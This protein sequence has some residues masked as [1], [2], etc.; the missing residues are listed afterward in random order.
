[1]KKYL[2]YFFSIGLMSIG[3]AQNGP[4]G[5][6][7][8]TTLNLWLKT[9]N[10]NYND[11]ELVDTWEDAS[12]N[13][14]NASQAEENNRPSFT[15]TSNLNGLP[16]LQFA[17]G[18]STATGDFLRI[19]GSASNFGGINQMSIFSAVRPTN[20]SNP[21]GQAIISKRQDTNTSDNY[22]FS[23][24]FWTDNRTY[25]D[26]SGGG[27]VGNR[28]D[29]G[30]ESVV[31]NNNN[32]LINASFDGTLPDNEKQEIFKNASST[33]GTND[34]GTSSI[35]A[36]DQ[37][38]TIGKI[39]VSDNRYFAGQIPEI[40]FYNTAV[41]QTQRNII[42]NY[43]SAKF[44][45]GI[46]SNDIYTFDDNASGDFD[47]HVIGIGQEASTDNHINSKGSGIIRVNNPTNLNDGEYLFIGSESLTETDVDLSS[48]DCSSS[49]ADNILSQNTWRVGKY[50]GDLG[51]VDIFFDVADFDYAPMN[52]ELVVSDNEDFTNPTIY[53]SDDPSGGSTIVAF[54]GINFNNGDYIKLRFASVQP[55]V[56]DG[57][58]FENGSGTSGEPTIADF[59]KKLIINGTGAELTDD[60]ACFCLRVETNQ[61]FDIGNNELSIQ[62]SLSNSG[63]IDALQGS[64]RFSESE[65]L[66]E[67]SGA[68]FDIGSLIVESDVSINTDSGDH[69]GVNNLLTVDQ[70]TLTTNDKLV[71]RCD[72]V[73]GAAQ[74]APVSGSIVGN[75]E[76]QQCYPAKRAWR[77]VS[78]SATT[79]TSIHA[80]W[81]ENA[82]G[83]END[84]NPGFGTHITGVSP[85]SANAD[86]AQDG[87]NGFDYNPSGN[88]S[89]FT[90]DNVNQSWEVQP[91]TTSTLTAGTPYRLL[92]RGD[93]SID[94]TSND[95]LPEDTRLRET[96]ALAVGTQN[97]SG[98]NAGNGAFNIFGNPY[99]A[100]VNMNEVF[101]NSTNIDT[102]A[103]YVWDPQIN[104]R[105]GYVTISL[106]NGDNSVSS[107][108]NAYLQPKQAAFFIADGNGAPTLTFNESYK[109]AEQDQTE[110]FSQ[111]NEVYLNMKLHSQESFTNGDK[112]F[113]G[114]RI[115]FN[116]AYTNSSEDDYPKLG[117]QDENLARAN[118]NYFAALEYR[119]MPLENEVLPLFINQYRNETYV[120]ELDIVGEL[121][122]E[123][124]IY[125]AYLDEQVEVTETNFVYE[126]EIDASIPESVAQ[127]RFELNFGSE[128]FSSEEFENNNISLYPN[129]SSNGYFK[130]SGSALEGA[131]KLSIFDQLGRKVYETEV[132]ASGAIEV[133][134]FKASSGLYLI[135]LNNKNVGNQTIKLMVK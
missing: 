118:D 54:E 18:N 122:R 135:Q 72:F 119:E 7:S 66:Q 132:N 79:T 43:L 116:E 16:A 75:V 64:I 29:G 33:N 23:L 117:N 130:L 82:T 2:F 49:S 44:D 96:G 27:G 53:E 65:I 56:W 78:P 60:A 26:I 126:F 70:G 5:V 14:N 120:F 35:N 40:I 62:S 45:I 114:L 25:L 85:G 31:T 90:F 121:G 102:G 6:G 101:S 38:V 32:F 125:D 3:F 91:N 99:Q 133:N 107:D 61:S 108:A 57:T 34:I 20:V 113:D 84:P 92:I 111:E 68:G 109:A 19:P 59:G 106:P 95:A 73:N 42:D 9:D 81:Q 87:T 4:G 10:L 97:F 128:T 55:I 80:N 93:R 37:D 36:S 127:D 83:F 129:P 74:V 1:M 48:I 71:L 94:I 50:G 112:A 105:G 39:D 13:A 30:S 46:G 104:S 131:T 63:E 69:V 15:S 124:F 77:F 98:F 28:L 123:L 67:I 12:E 100:V 21:L 110:V 134:D 22:S 52:V 51:N 89:I 86:E 115:H 47:F 24:F 88:P 103:Y 58:S 8:E 11:G 17:G 41:N 76:T